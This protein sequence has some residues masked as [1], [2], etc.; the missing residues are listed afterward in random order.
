MFSERD[1]QYNR[2]IIAPL[3]QVTRIIDVA[4]ASCI[5][6]L[7]NALSNSRPEML[8]KTILVTGASGFVGSAV[9]ERFAAEGHSMRIT[10]RG[11]AQPFGRDGVRQYGGVDLRAPG[12]WTAPLEGADVVVHCGARVH[13]V[14]ELS[15]DPMTEFRRDNVEATLALAT[16]AAKVGVKRFVYV[17]SIG[18]NGAET[19]DRPFGPDDAPA[20]HSPYAQSKLEAERALK[21]LAVHTGLE[22]AIVRPPL[23][24]GPLAP[25]NFGALVRTVLRGT[26]LP[27]GAVRN[28]R[29]LVARANLVDLLLRCAVDTQ[30]AG[31]TLMVSDGDD[32]S[33]PE[34][35]HHIGRALGRPVRLF[36]VPPAPM[37]TLA[38]WLGRAAILQ[39]LCGSLQ[40]D[41]T[42]TCL[43]LNWTPPVR[44]TDAVG[45]AARSYLPG[46]A[47]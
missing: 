37:R 41:I 39:S 32:I 26:P 42:R 16:Q 30:A 20:P 7:G 38:G 23:V 45:E 11:A 1:L 47:A 19:F 13:V 3:S 14:K 34:L 43:L 22:L 40:V 15:L 36:P 5:G 6:L 46:P 17:S 31:H 4:T 33:T 35:L 2:G 27:F 44:F 25:G 12:S 29:S 21:T 24:Y 8:K 18:V 28:R 10:S 9:V